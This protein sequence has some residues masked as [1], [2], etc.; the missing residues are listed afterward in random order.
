[1]PT[2]R[3]RCSV[4]RIRDFSFLLI[5]W[6]FLSAQNY[7]CRGVTSQG[8]LRCPR[9]LL[10]SGGSSLSLGNPISAGRMAPAVVCDPS[11]A[12]GCSRRAAGGEARL[13]CSSELVFIGPRG[14]VYWSHQGQ[15]RKGCVRSSVRTP[16]CD[17]K[18]L[19]PCMSLGQNGIWSCL[20]GD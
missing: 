16:F 20:A 4:M 10:S 1:M 6:L 18:L 14:R 15:G 2:N 11:S 9:G 12:P 7:P 19:K 17:L 8:F 5:H 13:P 3:Q